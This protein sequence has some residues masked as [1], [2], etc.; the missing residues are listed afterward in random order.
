MLA[1]ENT[2]TGFELLFCK[3]LSRQTAAFL[4]FDRNSLMISRAR[5]DAPVQEARAAVDTANGS[6]CC[7]SKTLR[8]RLFLWRSADLFEVPGFVVEDDVPQ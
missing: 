4:N 3:I 2:W 7:L 1:R 6:R 8:L 5:A